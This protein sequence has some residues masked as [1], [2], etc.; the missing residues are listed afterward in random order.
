[1][2]VQEQNITRA[3]IPL[4]GKVAE[5]RF[6]K[7]DTGAQFNSEYNNK[8][9]GHNKICYIQSLISVEEVLKL[10]L[11]IYELSTLIQIADEMISGNIS[12][13]TKM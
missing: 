9:L 13:F 1:M 12:I 6:N 3:L 5:K 10:C 4:S 2:Y 8:K 11:N 7:F